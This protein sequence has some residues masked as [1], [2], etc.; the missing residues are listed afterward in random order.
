[1]WR[2]SSSQDIFPHPRI[3][4]SVLS[5]AAA[6]N[7][8]SSSVIVLL[9][10]V[11]M[12]ALT[13]SKND[14]LK[15]ENEELYHSLALR[16]FPQHIAND[17][18]DD[19]EMWNPGQYNLREGLENRS[20]EGYIALLAEFLESCNSHRLPYNARETIWLF[21]LP[22]LTRFRRVN[23]SK[24]IQLRF[25][26]ALRSVL[27]SP[28]HNAEVL[29]TVAN[30]RVFT[31]IIGANETENQFIWLDDPDACQVVRESLIQFLSATSLSLGP[32]V[33]H[34]LREIAEK[35]ADPGSD[36]GRGGS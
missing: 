20:Q 33:T 1:M 5:S 19:A 10:A 36:F 24:T 28:H 26:N 12:N 30:L 31:T 4:E 32:G 14:G 27:Q 11:S 29:E 2:Q 6:V 9:K 25:A 13:T 15:C 3:F 7:V 34:K 35:I 23:T 16:I 21:D 17:H 22:S 8:P 18:G